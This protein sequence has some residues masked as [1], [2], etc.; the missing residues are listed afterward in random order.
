M[1]RYRWLV[2][3]LDGTLFDYDAAEVHALT[4]AFAEIGVEFGGLY[5]LGVWV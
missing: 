3:D 1:T 5:R 4:L 2:F